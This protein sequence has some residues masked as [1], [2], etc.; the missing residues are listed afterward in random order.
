MDL[1][2][3]YE[4]DLG[5]FRNLSGL[6]RSEARLIMEELRKDSVLFASRR[7]DGYMDIRRELE[8][9][10]R[11]MFIQKGGMP[12]LSYPHY[13]T[14][15]E[16][17]WIKEWYR[18]GREIRIPLGEFAGSS[19][20][21][22]YG[23]LFPTMRYKDGKP[24]RENVYTKREIEEL[25]ARHGLPQQWNPDGQGGPERYI[26]VQV[27]DDAVLRRYMPLES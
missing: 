9:K 23:D 21:F 13:M 25:I 24:Y 7:P 3:Y 11:A 16:C 18:D 19:I 27:W 20:S 8:A 14:V 2:H 4:A 1:Y 17:A 10:A 26:E 6:N 5:P 15:G 22:T 12:V